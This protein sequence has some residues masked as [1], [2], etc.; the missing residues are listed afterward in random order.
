MG[1]TS[2]YCLKFRLFLKIKK[3]WYEGMKKIISDL[4]NLTKST[5]PSQLL[6]EAPFPYNYLM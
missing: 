2:G 6:D 4:W 1:N 5:G 3:M